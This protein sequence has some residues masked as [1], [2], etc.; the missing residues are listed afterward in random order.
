MLTTGTIRNM[1]QARMIAAAVL[2]VSLCAAAGYAKPSFTGRFTLPYEVNWGKNTLPAGNYVIIIEEV[3]RQATVESLDGHI[4]FF[5]PMPIKLDSDGGSTGLVVLVRGN[6][7]VVRLLN[8]PHA[9][10]SLVYQPQTSAER[11]LLV[12]ADRVEAVPLV[13]GAK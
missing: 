9:G 13:A 1:I 4:A 7:R 3:G 10:V 8:L 11:E 6:E 5:T 2:V 12:K